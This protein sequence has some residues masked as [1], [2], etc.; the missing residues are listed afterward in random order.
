MQKSVAEVACGQKLFQPSS[1]KQKSQFYLG[2]N[3]LNQ[4]IVFPEL[5]CS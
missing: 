2:S 3:E 4:R 1:L 5:P